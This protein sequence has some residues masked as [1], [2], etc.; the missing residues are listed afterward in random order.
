VKIALVPKRGLQYGPPREALL[1]GA[2]PAAK[3]SEASEASEPEAE[4]LDL[5]IPLPLDPAK[6][7]TPAE[8]IL[9]DMIHKGEAFMDELREGLES[10]TTKEQGEEEHE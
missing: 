4:S 8:V 3:A 10:I 7:Q 6:V 1:E 2:K 5:C 9:K